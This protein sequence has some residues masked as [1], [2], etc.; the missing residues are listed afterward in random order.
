MAQLARDALAAGLTHERSASNDQRLLTLAGCIQGLVL[1]FDEHARYLNAWADDPAL[2]A[3]SA[4]A[5]IGRTIDA[6]L[7]PVVGAPFTAMVRRVF[8]SGTSEQIEYPLPL[9]GSVHWFS[10]DVKRVGTSPNMTVVFFARDITER[11]NAE[12]ALQRSEELYR[13][14]A[15]ATKDALWDWDLP[16]GALTWSA[17][18]ASVFMEPE[19]GG[20][21]SWWKDRIHPE[22]APRIKASI[23]AA[24]A[25]D[26]ESWSGG[27]RWRRGDGTYGDFLD[28]GFIVR[29]GGQ[30]TRM[31]GSMADMTQLNRLQAQLVQ[32]DRL[33]AVGLL[34]AGVGH[35]INNPLSYVLGNLEAVQDSAA[36]ANECDGD[37]RAA[38]REAFEGA[39]QIAEIVRNLKSFSRSETRR[40]EVD[41]HPLL[42]RSLRIAENEIRHRAR[43]ERDFGAVPAITASESELA[44]VFLNLLINAAQAIVEGSK[45]ENVIRV[46]TGLDA[47][48]RVFISVSDTGEGIRAEDICHVFDPFF[49]TKPVG[50]GTGLGLSICHGI[51]QAM[52]GEM[53]VE[54]AP[55]E[56]TTFTVLLPVAAASE[57]KSTVG[58][59]PL[60]QPLSAPR[61][62]RLL[63]IDDEIAVAKCVARMLRAECDVVIVATAV[64]GLAKL[65]ADPPFDAVLCDLMM[66]HMSGMDFYD[67]VCAAH[68]QIVS[69][70]FFMTGGAFTSRA[71]Q[72][73]ESLAHPPLDKPL[74]AA[75]LRSML[76]TAALRVSA[77]S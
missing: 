42:E 14:A 2:L 53:T 46:A 27:Y 45:D 61:R 8:Q 6:V 22:D 56:R 68:P 24:L 15:R 66:P 13:L 12:E 28:R 1:E 18:A 29:H 51:V 64:E 16:S 20:H 10:A 72:F 71:T 39:L 76:E 32:A 73:V 17:S 65:D 47:R 50:I 63:V 58:G 62:M 69:R 41:I 48:G 30:A 55:G 33:A 54:S 38:I 49:T 40:T 19:V 44:Q 26:A 57:A 52:G 23:E 37:A 67:A 4:D 74:R 21:I 59:V 7:G 43:L 70:L 75:A 25:G 3:G 36:F 77:S 9:R 35:E 34:A 31:V 60:T 11:R 5:M